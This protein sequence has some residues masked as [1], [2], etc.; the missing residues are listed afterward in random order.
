MS[1]Y[2]VVVILLAV[3]LYYHHTDVCEVNLDCMLHKS[4]DMALLQVTSQRR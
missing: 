1:P 4:C 2:N 3:Q